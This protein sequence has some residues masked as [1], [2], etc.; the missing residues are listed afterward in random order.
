[1]HSAAAASGAAGSLLYSIVPGSSEQSI[2]LYRMRS[3]KPDE[4]MPELGRSLIHDE[5]I[6]L[7]TR[8][9]ANMT[10]SCLE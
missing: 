7:I 6:D 9:L 3:E 10:G 1:M 4:M 2:M 5:G 8:W